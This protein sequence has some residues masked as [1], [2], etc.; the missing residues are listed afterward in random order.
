[1]HVEFWN[2]SEP[3]GSLLAC[4]VS[5]TWPRVFPWTKLTAGGICQ[6]RQQ[7]CYGDCLQTENFHTV[8]W[9]VGT[10]KTVWDASLFQTIENTVEKGSS[11]FCF[12]DILNSKF[13][14][15]QFVLHLIYSRTGFL[16]GVITDKIIIFLWR[17]FLFFAGCLAASLISRHLTSSSLLLS[18]NNQKCL[19]TLLVYRW[20]KV[21][22]CW[23]L[24]F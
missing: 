23:E 24:L 7:S 20:D 17:A 11:P 6:Q 12:V 16:N 15:S 9:Y 13:V 19:E 1:M 2:S 3:S 10:N 22:P 8:V 5:V 18:C 21:T 4:C 14:V